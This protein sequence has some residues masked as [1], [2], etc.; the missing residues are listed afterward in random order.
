M[1]DII[2][3]KLVRFETLLIKFAK[4]NEIP[5]EFLDGSMNLDT[6]TKQYKH[7]LSEYHLK[8]STKLKRL[9]SSRIKKSSENLYE[10]FM[11]EYLQFYNNQCT[12]ED[13]WKYDIVSSKYRK[14][15]N[16]IRAL[17]YELLNIMNSYN[18]DSPTHIF[19]LDL[20]SD[21]GWRNTIINCVQKDI[22]TIDK[23]ISTYHYPLEK[24]GDKPFEFLYLI[25]LRKDL[26]TARSI[27]RSMGHWTPDE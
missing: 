19:V 2:D 9:L 1:D 8:L 23:I 4:T 11:E 14:N 26:I 27:F 10:S 25:E 3:F 21:A 24:I 7:V 22:N 12:R 15:L 5:H 20:F 16:P 17:Y 18:P 6:L 13:K